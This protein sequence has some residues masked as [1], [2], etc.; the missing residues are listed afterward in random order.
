MDY[1]RTLDINVQ[2]L[3]IDKYFLEMTPKALNI[4]EKFDT[5][6]FIKI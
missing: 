2:G 3:G 1:T 5:M 6:N 4:K